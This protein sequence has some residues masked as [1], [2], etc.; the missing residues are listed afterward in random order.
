MKI[1][2]L[3]YS[4]TVG[5][6]EKLVSDICNE[7]ARCGHSVYLYIV[8]NNYSNELLQFLGKN[9][10]I[11]LQNRSVG[12]GDKVKT[13][14]KISQFIIKE[15]IDVVHCNALTTP[16]LLFLKPFLFP[17]VRIIHTV[18]DVGQYEKLHRWNVRYRNYICDS[19]VAISESVKNDIIKYGADKKKVSVVYNAINCARF[20]TISNRQ[21][22]STHY[23]IGNVARIMPEKKGQD[24]LIKAIALLKD[25]YPEIKCY[26]AGGYDDSHQASYN[27]L[28]KLVDK[29]ELEQNIVFMGNVIDI[30]TLLS[31]LDIFVLPSRYEGFGISLIEAMASGIPCI[32]SSLDGPA[33]II[34]NDLRGILFEVGNHYELAKGIEAII[35]DFN[36]YHHIAETAK[37]YVFNNFSIETMCSRLEVIYEGTIRN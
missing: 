15:K 14:L 34:G 10:H 9:V 32:A 30:S 7:M 6:S 35:C 22:H 33:E 3:M 31:E 8:N 36:K 16:E 4:F 24:I 21:I 11:E 19:I 29:Y 1:M 2:Y 25:K 18:H 26:F 27:E 17:K 5:G 23:A 37:M 20:K 12:G 28:L 13:I